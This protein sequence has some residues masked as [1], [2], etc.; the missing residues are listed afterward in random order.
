MNLKFYLNMLSQAS[1][2]MASAIS[3]TGLVLLGFGI[4]IYALPELFATLAALFFFIAGI[5]CL[6]TS[7]KIFLANRRFNKANRNSD[8]AY[9]KNVR[10]HSEENHFDI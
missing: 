7:L 9:R 6:S 10:I 1:R 8:D 2:T 5:G 3:V 4:L